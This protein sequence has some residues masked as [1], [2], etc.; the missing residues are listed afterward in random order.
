M[1]T[2]QFTKNETLWLQLEQELF[3][4][5]YKIET[6]DYPAKFITP[7]FSLDDITLHEVLCHYQQLAL[8]DAFRQELNFETQRYC[9]SRFTNKHQSL[10]YLPLL[11]YY[12]IN[13]SKY[14]ASFEYLTVQELLATIKKN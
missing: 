10:A 11:S 6:D 5:Q 7:S 8:L 3:S 12:A 14:G 13:L 4:K 9:L 2:E 1:K